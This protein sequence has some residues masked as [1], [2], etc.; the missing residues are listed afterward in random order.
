MSAVA[1]PI[2]DADRAAMLSPRGLV[3]LSLVG[4]YLIWGSTYLAIRVALAD[5]PPFL[6]GAIRFFIAGALMF[7]A[8]LWR[9]VAA[10]TPKQWFNCAVTGLLLL[11]FGNGLVC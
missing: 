8:A 2:P 11:G 7:G 4:V 10:P 5:Y 9:G 3:A 6:M 1:D